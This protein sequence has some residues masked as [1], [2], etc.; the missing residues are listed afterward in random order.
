MDSE[1]KG[2]DYLGAVLDM[3]VYEDR[4]LRLLLMWKAL[5]LT[6]ML[7]RFSGKLRAERRVK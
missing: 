7:N 5:L 4:M 6:G 3:R 2:K 1:P